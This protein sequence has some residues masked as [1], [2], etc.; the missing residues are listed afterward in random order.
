MTKGVQDVAARLLR[1]DRDRL[2]DRERRVVEHFEERRRISRN[3]NKEFADQL[4]VGQ[5][6]A[7][8]VAAFGGSW[9]FIG[10][11]GF[12]LVSWVVLNAVVLARRDAA[13]DPYPFILLNLFLSML[14]AIQ[15]PVILMSQNRQ[16]AK[17]RIDAAH[18]YEV[19]LKAELEILTL[20]EKLDGL[21][22]QQWGELIALQERQIDF[23]RR[24]LV[25]NGIE[26]NGAASNEGTA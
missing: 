18:D 9:L 21:R 6:V 12:I 25:A 11:F 10:L 24:L 4:S 16:V 19:N 13:F 20:H 14:A 7:D 2:T 22:E 8:R 1:V 23:L 5:R 15:A 3:T 17:D 26:V